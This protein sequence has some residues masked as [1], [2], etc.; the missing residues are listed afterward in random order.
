MP[1]TAS[2]TTPSRPGGGKRTLQ[3]LRR[4]AGY[5]SAQ[6]FAEELGIPRSTYTHYEQC[7]DGPDTC[8]PVKAAW[9]IADALG[10]TIDLVVGRA[11]VDADPAPVQTFYN[12]LSG[13]G[14]D[15]M[16]E[17]MKLL[18]YREAEMREGRW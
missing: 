18:A 11:D 5:R 6:A 10:S 15:R 12:S 13:S 7:P 2:T 16:D 14:R 9:R 4:D 3:R 17:Y 8:I 1:T